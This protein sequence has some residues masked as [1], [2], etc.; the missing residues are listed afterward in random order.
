MNVIVVEDHQDLRNTFVDHLV[1]D[2]YHVLGASCGEEL[3]E[4]MAE[5]AVNLLILD[6]NLPG[7]NG[8]EIAHRIRA[9][10]AHINIIMLTVLAAEPDRI[11]GY[12]S[13]ADIYLAKPI[14][15]AELTAAVRA[16]AR[17]AQTT[18]TVATV[19]ELNVPRM[20][21]IGPGGEVALSKLDVAFLKALATAP[22]RRLPYWRLLEVTERSPDAEQSKSQ[23]ELQVFRL[24]KKIAKLGI[25][26]NLIKVI[27]Q[28]GY[29][30][31]EPVRVSD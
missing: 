1:Q 11:K 17:R 5:Q 21:L 18:M 15:P 13:G 16:I 4:L 22:K 28:E 31:S 26:E 14:S 29:Q 8:F 24:R 9:T 6:V 25:S 7:E 3:D 30:L 2:G 23:L 20:M 12:E 10:Y 27:W 19:L